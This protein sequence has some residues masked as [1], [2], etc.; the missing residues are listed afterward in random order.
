MVVNV[1]WSDTNTTYSKATSTSLGLVEL[2]SDTVQTTAANNVTTTASRTY[3]VQ[4]NAADQAVVNVPWTDTVYSLPIA[5]NSAL[6]GVKLGLAAAAAT[7]ENGTTTANRFY[8]VGA[9][10]DGTMYVNFPW[11][12]TNTTYSVANATTLGLVELFSNTQQAVAANTVSATA[13][14][15]YGLQLNAENQGV[16]NVPWTDTVA[17]AAAGGGLSATS[18]AFSM[19]NPFFAQADAPS[20]P[21]AGTIWFDL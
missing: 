20:S 4:L 11:S 17:T 1:P 6:G 9:L 16:I 3:G 2:F 7:L 12:D 19:V 15:T 8:R 5:T 10:T 13:S 21:V 18:N 14:R